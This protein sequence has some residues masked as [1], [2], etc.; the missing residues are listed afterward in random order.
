MFR[1]K[2]K[3]AGAWEVLP[4]GR[5]M[6]LVPQSPVLEAQHWAPII[7]GTPAPF[8]ASNKQTP[9]CQCEGY[10][11]WI[12]SRQAAAVCLEH[13]HSDK[14]HTKKSDLTF[15]NF[16]P[17]GCFPITSSWT[18]PSFPSWE[19]WLI[20]VVCKAFLA[21]N[22]RCCFFAVFVSVAKQLLPRSE[23]WLRVCGGG[24]GWKVEDIM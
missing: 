10:T 13:Q 20:S 17:H 1:E 23:M 2:A 15:N 9:S 6:C 3:A 4:S 14:K 16:F 18:C 12:P 24:G 22:K 21:L 11:W 5:S 19:I 7:P 8:A